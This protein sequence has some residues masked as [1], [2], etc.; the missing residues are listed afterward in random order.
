MRKAKR[1]DKE[2]IVELLRLSFIDNLSVGF[3]V[4]SS[5]GRNTRIRRLM[6]YAFDVCYEFGEV[7]VNEE[8]S[9]C[10]LLFY[11]HLKQ[12]SLSAVWLDIKLLFGVIGF[13]R[14]KKVLHREKLIENQHPKGPFCYLWFIGVDPAV[15]G[16]GIGSGLMAALLSKMDAQDL[17]VYLET[18]V[19]RNIS[20]YQKFG[21]QVF[22]QTELSY[23][24]LFL[25]RS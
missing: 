20:F 21:F 6:E 22:H 24:L 8:G 18:S 25:K 12:F 10:A 2:R 3:L 11:R 23:S 5:S 9:A 4:G 19:A 15:Q 13:A 14:L 7:V 16:K 1:S 17:P